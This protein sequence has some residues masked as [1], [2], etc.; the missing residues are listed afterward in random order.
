MQMLDVNVLLYA[1]RVECPQYSCYREW[2]DQLVNGPSQYAI[3]EPVLQA[4]GR[5]SRNPKFFDP[6]STMA[7][8]FEFIDALTS[9]P[10]CV[11]L[12]YCTA[13]NAFSFV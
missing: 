6:P 10:N 1:H 9:S 12:R 3:S 4:F 8:I 7:Q 11:V 5:V 2:L 13:S